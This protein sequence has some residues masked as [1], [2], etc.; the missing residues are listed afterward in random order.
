MAPCVDCSAD[1]AQLK[2]DINRVRDELRQK[3]KL[4]EKFLSVASAQAKHIDSLRT[5][6]QT[7]T[8][9]ARRQLV[10]SPPSRLSQMVSDSATTLPL[11]QSLNNSPPP[12][13]LTLS[14]SD[15][16]VWLRTGAR[17]RTHIC[18]STPNARG[19]L[20]RS[21]AHNDR[22]SSMPEQGAPWIPVTRGA[23]AR[24]PS[25]SPLHLPLEN[26]FDV[27]SL[28]EFPPLD[29]RPGSQQPTQRPFTLPCS[30]SIQAHAAPR[31][32]EV[33]SPDVL[34]VGTSMVRHVAVRAGRTFC[35]PG[36]RVT[37]VTS[38]ALQQCMHYSASTVVIQAGTNDI[39]DRQSEVLKKDFATSI[40]CLLDTGKR[41]VISGP[42]PAPRFGDV[43]FS[44]LYQL[45][46]WLK[47]YCLTKGVPFV[48]NFTTFLNRP[49]LF[50]RDRLHPNEQGS[51]LLSL[52]IDLT[53]RSSAKASD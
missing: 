31:Q 11:P 22:P 8:P 34:L 52:N 36:A 19:N 39:K 43:P 2:E 25:V 53:I 6:L 47:G 30:P 45:H 44:R 46:L 32:P 37:E 33:S 17:P 27:L 28:A 41:L 1:L 3:D 50:K 48:D 49:Q 18:S 4:L 21:A 15:E 35:H 9:P 26:R 38:S 10:V 51:R 40:D 24:S 23:V 42:I 13:A 29:T 14:H 12:K 16:Q 7:C 20:S 5:T